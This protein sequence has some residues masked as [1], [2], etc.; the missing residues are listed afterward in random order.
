M[1]R[2]LRTLNQNTIIFRRRGTD[3]VFEIRMTE[4]PTDDAVDN[5]YQT[6]AS[7]FESGICD[8]AVYIGDLGTP[9]GEW[10]TDDLRLQ[11][12][13]EMG[14]YGL[15]WADALTDVLTGK[16]PLLYFG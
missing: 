11:I 8:F 4:R 7:L 1:A 12:N 16:S 10:M 3:A 2:T 13:R 5:M 9:I 6:A 15:K 14:A